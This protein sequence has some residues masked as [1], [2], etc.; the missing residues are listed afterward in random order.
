MDIIAQGQEAPETQ[1]PQMTIAGLNTM[2]LSIAAT[3][4]GLFAI[5]TLSVRH[6]RH[7]ARR[8]LLGFVR[9]FGFA[10]AYAVIGLVYIPI[11]VLGFVSQAWPSCSE[12]EDEEEEVEGGYG[13]RKVGLVDK[14]GGGSRSSSGSSFGYGGYEDDEPGRAGQDLGAAAGRHYPAANSSTYTRSNSDVSAIDLNVAADLEKG[15]SSP[16]RNKTKPC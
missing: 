15:V 9:L 2:V 12:E 10:F 16:T 7:E 5:V 13:I 11:R 1:P 8:T 6:I 4:C 3:L 14:R